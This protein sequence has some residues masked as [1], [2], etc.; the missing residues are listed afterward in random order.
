MRFHWYALVKVCN[1]TRS[2]HYDSEQGSN[3]EWYFLLK[4]Y[5]LLKIFLHQAFDV[6][7]KVFFSFYSTS[8]RLFV[9]GHYGRSVFKLSS[10]FILCHNDS[11]VHL[12]FVVKSPIL[13]N[14]RM[15][16][17]SFLLYSLFNCFKPFEVSWIFVETCL[18][19][20]ISCPS[21]NLGHRR[22]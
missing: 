17:Y 18:L 12:W 6:I 20:W 7:S 2:H 16:V 3:S 11:V 21:V 1:S 13:T 10:D 14:K 8:S 15:R 4:V 5:H 9:P 19:E 22:K